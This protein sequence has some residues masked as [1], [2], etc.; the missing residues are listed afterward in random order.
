[1]IGSYASP[2]PVETG[3]FYHRWW[4]VKIETKPL[5]TTIT[6]A[7]L[8]T[9]AFPKIGLDW[10]AWVALAP[11][12]WALNS[13][14]P[15]EAF[16]RGIIFG[17]AHFLSL[18]YWLVP[19]MVKYGHLPLYLSIAILFL[20]ATILSLV[21]VGPMTWGFALAGQ[22]PA[23]A[24]VLFPVFWVA[25]DFLRSFLFTGFPWE[26]LGYS[27]YRRLH[28]IQIV[29]IVGVY[30]LSGLV[31]FTNAALLLGYLA[32]TGRPWCGKPVR[33]RFAL[34]GAAAAIAMVG[35][36]WIYGEVRIAQVDRMAAE[37][38]KARVAVIQGN[39]E[40]A[41]KWDPAFQKAAI[42]KYL[43]LSLSTLGKRPELIVWPES[44]A[45]FYFLAEGPPTRMV[46]QGIAEAATYFLIGAPAFE[47]RGEKADY[48][49]SAYL[50]GPRTE[51]LGRYDKAHLVPYGE[52]TPFKEYLPFLGKIVEHVGDFKP[53]EKGKTLEWM[54][55][56]LGIQI[57]YEIIFPELSRAQ[58]QNGARLL[59]TITNDAWYEKTAGPYQHFSLAVLR[60]VE[61]R[62][63]VA[64]AANTGISG[65]IDP[66]GRPLDLTP[67]MEEA[68]VVRELPLPDT[69]TLYTRWGDVWAWVCLI[70]S[71]G[72]I[73]W[74][75]RER[76]RKK[77]PS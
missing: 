51:V 10:L 75:Q 7:L 6:A 22:T 29:D 30:G 27:Q 68:A 69:L 76:Q 49:N 42:A 74:T 72:M 46:M 5:L 65:F 39:I 71:A 55:R 16:R 18:L 37:A 45:P 64:R 25:A 3:F 66:A 38:P 31:A 53:G 21:F 19:T 70:V 11:L 50:V 14:S 1:M 4:A 44:A 32:V 35:L 17:I 43:R 57:C 9:A 54:G 47:M 26:L 67:L 40:Q 77:R 13:V 52:Y 2:Y 20:F 41:Q 62:R 56:K 15:G 63:V 33:G 24:L 73:I 59:I 60:A 36:T 48:Y 8:L 23:R 34:A 58:V 12:L 28:L 61:N